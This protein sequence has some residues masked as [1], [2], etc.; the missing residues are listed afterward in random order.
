MFKFAVYATVHAHIEVFGEVG[1]ICRSHKRKHCMPA[2]IRK[3]LVATF[4]KFSSYKRLLSD[5]RVFH[6]LLRMGSL[7]K[8]QIVRSV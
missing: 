4:S 8:V 7:C 2:D 1:N 5:L 6:G 3:K